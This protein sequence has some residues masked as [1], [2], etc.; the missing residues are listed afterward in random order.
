MTKYDCVLKRCA[1]IVCSC[2]VV[3]GLVLLAQIQEQKRQ[4]QT[5]QHLKT[6]MEWLLMRSETESAKEESGQAVKELEERISALRLAY[7]K[8][9]YLESIAEKT[10]REN[11]AASCIE[12]YFKIEKGELEKILGEAEA[13]DKLKTDFPDAGHWGYLLAA[14]EKIWVQYEADAPQNALPV[15]LVI[16]N[17]QLD[18]GY[19]DARAGM[20]LFDIEDSYPGSEVEEAEL[21]WGVTRYLRYTDEAFVYYYVAVDEMGDAVITYIVPNKD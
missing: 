9:T 15:G 1:M 13:A 12:R 4:M 5:L 14:G 6:E 11:R 10:D 18:M 19:K 20:Y 8:G 2:C 21:D 17:P 3:C 7:D 16:E